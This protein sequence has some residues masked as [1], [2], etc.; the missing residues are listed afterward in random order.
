MNKYP[1]LLTMLIIGIGSNA[2]AGDYF[3][4]S[5]LATD[6]GNNDKL[7]L[8]L[9]SHPGGES[10]ERERLVY[11]LMIFFTKMLHWTL[12]MEFPEP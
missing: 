12:K 5:L 6:I 8:S 10:K 4:P 11:I 9:F 1:P 7:D 3:D 2:V